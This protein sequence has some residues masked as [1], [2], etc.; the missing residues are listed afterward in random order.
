ML[1]TTKTNLLE[2]KTSLKQNQAIQN[3]PAAWLLVPRCLIMLPPTHLPVQC[4]PLSVEH[5]KHVR[6]SGSYKKF[7]A[8]EV[9][10]SSL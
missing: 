10:G 7:K 5:G 2:I 8:R 6:R 9:V 1:N 4:Q 3:Q